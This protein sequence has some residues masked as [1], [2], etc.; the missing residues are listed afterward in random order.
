MTQD[1]RRERSTK[2]DKFS[3]RYNAIM[4]TILAVGGTVFAAFV[5]DQIKEI[6]QDHIDVQTT[7]QQ[8]NYIQQDLLTFK[9]DVAG[10]NEDQKQTDGRQDQQIQEIKQLYYIGKRDQ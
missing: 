3:T 6:R 2:I 1:E 9:V 10:Q 4:T 8:V 5:S 7:K